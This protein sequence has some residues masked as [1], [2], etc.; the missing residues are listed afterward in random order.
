MCKVSDVR[1]CHVNFVWNPLHSY[2]DE[3][4]KNDFRLLYLQFTLHHFYSFLWS[5]NINML[6]SS[7]V[8]YFARVKGLVKN[9]PTE[10]QLF[11]RFSALSGV[12]YWA[13]LVNAQTPFPF[14]VVW[15]VGSGYISSW[16]LLFH[17]SKAKLAFSSLIYG[18][19]EVLL[20]RHFNLAEYCLLGSLVTY[21]K[22]KDINTNKIRVPKC[23]TQTLT[24]QALRHQSRPL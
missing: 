19:D 6:Y 13:M 24:K 4:Q 15:N 21:T 18:N 8:T 3:C 23:G 22:V 20:H 14:E 16:S 5:F 11:T 2:V 9:H 1:G 17:I 12:L 10:K 7:T